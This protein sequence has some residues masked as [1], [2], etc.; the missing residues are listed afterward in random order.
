MA[1]NFKPLFNCILFP[2][3]LVVLS[4]CGK[5]TS[6]P[7]TSAALQNSIDDSILSDTV[8]FEKTTDSSPGTSSSS[9][10]L[11]SQSETVQPVVLLKTSQGDI[12]IELDWENTP[13]T[14]ENFLNYVQEKHYDGTIFHQVI[15]GYLVLAGIFDDQGNEKAS[16]VP[17]RNEAHKGGKNVR[18]SVGMARLPGA[19]D[20]ATCEFYISLQENPALDHQGD[21]ADAYGYCV[22]GK[23]V[24]GLDIVEKISNLDVKDQESFQPLETVLIESA[25]QIR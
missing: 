22:F 15:P 4:G 17:I 18:G 3:I 20:S 24:E 8:P 16:G 23:V 10:P 12:R 11:A 9:T 14:A 21:E 5:E 19:I 13:L 1:S 25:T 7:P 6:N 2:L